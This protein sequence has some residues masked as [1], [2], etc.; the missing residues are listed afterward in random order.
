[1]V[2]NLTQDKLSSVK[3]HN[4]VVAMVKSDRVYVLALGQ[5]NGTMF[6]PL[7]YGCDYRY[8]GKNAELS[9]KSALQNDEKVVMCDTHQELFRHCT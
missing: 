1:M 6:V 4:K 3:L 7:N 2:T 8:K 9:V 5:K